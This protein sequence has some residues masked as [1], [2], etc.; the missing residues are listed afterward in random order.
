MTTA[1]TGIAHSEYNT[2]KEKQVHFLQI[3]VKPKKSRLAPAYHTKYFPDELKHNKLALLV[4]N[5]ADPASKSVI[6]INAGVA[7]YASIL[8]PGHKVKHTISAK[9]AYIHLI[10]TSGWQTPAQCAQI[11]VNGEDLSE[12]DGLFVRGQGDLEIESFGHTPA[13]FLLFDMDE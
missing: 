3:W 6:P 5:V 4:K 8:S 2:N 1:G 7:M 13:E 9:I 10:M 12:G 11:R